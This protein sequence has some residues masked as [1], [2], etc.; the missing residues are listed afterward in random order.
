MRY[1]GTH[2]VQFIYGAAGIFELYFFND[3]I[4]QLFA[5]GSFALQAGLQIKYIFH[6][7]KTKVTNSQ[8]VSSYP[9]VSA[10]IGVST[11]L[12]CYESH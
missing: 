5:V 9:K 12:C 10:Y 6:A 2:Q 8:K 3:R 1:I 7:V 11:Y 4:S